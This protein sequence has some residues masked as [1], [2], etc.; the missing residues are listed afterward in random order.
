MWLTWYWPHL[1][2]LVYKIA[3]LDQQAFLCLPVFLLLI[4]LLMIFF[5]ANIFYQQAFLCLS[6]SLLMWI[7]LIVHAC[8]LEMG[9]LSPKQ[10][11]SPQWRW[12]DSPIL[13]VDHIGGTLRQQ[14]FMSLLAMFSCKYSSIKDKKKNIVMSIY[15]GLKRNIVWYQHYTVCFIQRTKCNWIVLFSICHTMN[16]FFFKI[17]PQSCKEGERSTEQ[18]TPVVMIPLKEQE[19]TSAS[20]Q[21]CSSP[22][23]R[24]NMGSAESQDVDQTSVMSEVCY[25]LFCYLTNLWNTY[26]LV[27]VNIYT[28]VA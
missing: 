4:I 10:V 18:T 6:Q 19:L 17:R 24:E 26:M 2:W 5:Y 21:N 15:C 23:D 22:V 25:R 9:I 14:F 3:N 16:A 8:F 7:I 1:W 28:L 13:S 27:N 11:L 20:S 12:V